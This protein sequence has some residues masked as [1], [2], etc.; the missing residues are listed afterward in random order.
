MND[1]YSALVFTLNTLG[2]WITAP[3]QKPI[4]KGMF[5]ADLVANGFEKRYL[6]HL[7]AASVLKKV[8]TKWQGG[9]RNTYVM[10]LPPEVKL[11]D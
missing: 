10:P 9:W 1:D 7:V 6:K 4:G 11:P 5:E 8:T 2:R 3:D